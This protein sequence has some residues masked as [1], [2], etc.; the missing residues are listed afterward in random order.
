[1]NEFYKYL[2]SQVGKNI[3][4]L[5]GFASQ[6]ICVIFK[7]EISR[8]V[9]YFSKHELSSKRNTDIFF[10]LLND[11]KERIFTPLESET[12]KSRIGNNYCLFYFYCIYFY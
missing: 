8:Q 9:M 12:L 10:I 5:A 4:I 3:G 7:H 1:M 2:K 11:G 6:Y